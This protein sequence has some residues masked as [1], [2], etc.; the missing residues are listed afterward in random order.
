[1]VLVERTPPPE[2]STLA[3]DGV[4]TDHA[5]G[6]GLAVR[7]LARLGHRRIGLVACRGN[8]TTPAVRTGWAQAVAEL[9]LQRDVP[10]VDVPVY[11]TRGWVSAV[12]QALLRCQEERV[13][14]L[15]VHSD[16]EAIGV[17]ERARELGIA[18]PGELAVVS[19][20][21]EVAAAATPPIT[22][23]RPDK[24]RLG[25]LAMELALSRLEAGPERPV[26]RIALWPQVVV[27]ESCGQ[28]ADPAA[29]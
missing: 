26:H 4:I 21:D 27:R 8:P 3:L 29:P 7:H 17:L 15:L 28:G 1:M 18:V 20:D 24:H 16:W 19:Y 9:D 10:D 23:V 12:D 22:A 11:G 5:L 25:A 2:L 6:A 13:P 14:A